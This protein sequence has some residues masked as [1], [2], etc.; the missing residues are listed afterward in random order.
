ML[1]LELPFETLEEIIGYLDKPA[2]LFNL[3]SASK[4]LASVIIPRHLQYRIISCRLDTHSVWKQ[5]SDDRSLAQNVR[6]LEIQRDQWGYAY[7]QPDRLRVPVDLE[8]TYVPVLGRDFSEDGLEKE[9][10]LELELISA[11][12]N[13]SNLT[14][15]KWDRAPPLIDARSGGETEDLW[16]A[17][18]GCSDLRELSVVDAGDHSMLEHWALDSDG[19]FLKPIWDS[20]VCC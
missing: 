10:C 5:L 2:D 13:M 17:L 19:R 7:R 11:L 3:A 16:A 1:I 8:P 4:L 15:F 14:H 12:K 6:K 20:N 18:K 9:R